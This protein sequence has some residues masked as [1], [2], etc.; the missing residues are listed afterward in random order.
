ML[1]LLLILNV[2]SN[3]LYDYPLIIFKIP[4]I[5]LLNLSS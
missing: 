1:F 2:N 3:I 4:A 5:Q